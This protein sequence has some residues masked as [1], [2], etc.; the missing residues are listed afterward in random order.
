MHVELSRAEGADKPVARY[1]VLHDTS[2]NVCADVSKFE[3]ADFPHKRWNLAD[4]WSDDEQ[5]HLF[6]T[7]E[8]KLVAPKGR[9]FSV[10]WRATQLEKIVGTVSRGLFLHVEHVQLRSVELLPGQSPKNAKGDCRND[11]LAQM[12]GFSPAQ[13]DRSALTYIAASLRR[14]EW[15][16]PASH[17]ALDEG[18]QSGHDDPQNFDVKIWTK[19]ICRHLVKLARA[20]AS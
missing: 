10:P 14:G 4:R 17:A 13:M 8:G 15:L 3:G 18:V 19:S 5:A 2:V 1:F 11:R 9:T 12:P 6:I 7:R 20:C 16:I